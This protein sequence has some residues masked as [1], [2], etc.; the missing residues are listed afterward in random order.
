MSV[1]TGGNDDAWFNYDKLQ[2][3]RRLK[4]PEKHAINR[5]EQNSFYLLS[6]DV[7]RLNDQT[8][9]SVFKVNV[10]D[11][12]YFASLVNIIVLGTTPETKPF[13]IQARDLKMLIRDYSPREVVIDTN[14]IGVGLADEM[15]K[16]QVTPNGEVLPA[17]GFM[18]DKDYKKI[19]PKD[20]PM[21]L[22]G[23][24][25]NASLNS[26]IHANCYSRLHNGKVRLL[27]SEQDAK[28]ALMSTKKGQKMKP[29]DR[30]R[31]LLPHQMTTKLLEEMANL[32]LKRT[33]NNL[34]IT[35][36][37]INPRFPK[38]KYSSFSYGLWRI[39]EL[40]EENTKRLKR[41]N[42]SNNRALVFFTKGC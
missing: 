25:A 1:W 23:I 5:G 12:R 3:Y 41:Y 11:G 38:D 9:V 17:Y 40:E 24:K 10:R 6:T 2:R 27:I 28:V 22:Y 34:E 31:R 18:N 32:R 42:A 19:Q 35:L 30:V 14:G 33:G 26:S 37:R 39:K 29:E 13:S 7:G 4:N 21:I 20:A 15:I 16:T 36:E 8:V